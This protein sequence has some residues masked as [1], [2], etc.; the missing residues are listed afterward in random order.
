[1]LDKIALLYPIANILS[2]SIFCL[3]SHFFFFWIKFCT[4]HIG[5][6]CLLLSFYFILFYLYILLAF[7]Y[8][9]KK[10]LKYSYKFCF[11]NKCVTFCLYI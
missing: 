3:S 8:F 5:S 10:K 1:M 4:V 7:A 11:N 2:F 9:I 6:F